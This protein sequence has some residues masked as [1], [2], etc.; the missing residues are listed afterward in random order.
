MQSVELKPA[1]QTIKFPEPSKGSPQQERD[2]NRYSSTHNARLLTPQEVAERF[3]VSQR[4]V[5]DHASRRSPRI[6]AVRLGS[7]LR[8]RLA[9]VEDFL[10]QHLL[11]TTSKK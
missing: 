9:D 4:W 8:F 7:L 1:F 3:G 10:T 2:L 5:R 6:P 11:C